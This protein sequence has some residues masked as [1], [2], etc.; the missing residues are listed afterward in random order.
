MA[1]II[2]GDAQDVVGTTGIIGITGAT[3]TTPPGGTVTG[4]GIT[5]TGAGETAAPIRLSVR[6]SGRASATVPIILTVTEMTATVTA[7]ATP[8]GTTTAAATPAGTTDAAA[9][10]ITKQNL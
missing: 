5:G 1:A 2:V 4:T 7:A 9:T 8:A 10:V 3:G 6:D